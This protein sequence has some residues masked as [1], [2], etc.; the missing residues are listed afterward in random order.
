MSLTQTQIDGLRSAYQEA[1][2]LGGRAGATIYYRELAKYF[3]YGELALDVQLEQSLPG[4]VAKNYASNKITRD[5]S[6]K[7]RRMLTPDRRPILAL[8]H[9]RCMAFL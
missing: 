1:I 8:T 6:V 3:L 9:S 7:R 5:L 2:S 4:L